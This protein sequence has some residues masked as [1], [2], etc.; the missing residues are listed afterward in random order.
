M[1]SVLLVRILCFAVSYFVFEQICWRS[2]LM[3]LT[4]LLYGVTMHKVTVNFVVVFEGRV[5]GGGRHFY[6]LLFR[7]NEI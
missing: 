5:W 7:I 4:C 6:L 1:Y 3:H 2:T